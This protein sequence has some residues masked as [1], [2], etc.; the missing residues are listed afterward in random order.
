MFI[1]LYYKSSKQVLHCQVNYINYFY[2]MKVFIYGTIGS[3][4]R[5][6]EIISQIESTKDSA[7]DVYI[8]SPGGSVYE[9]FAIYNALQRHSEKVSTYIDGLAY[10]A[11]SWIS[12][13][14]PAG[15]RFMSRASHF[16]IHQ[17]LNMGGGNKADLEDQ[18]EQL[19]K[20]DEV[21]EFIYSTSSGLSSESI[22]G[23]MESGKPLSYEQALANG[24][25]DGEG[26]DYVQ[27]LA[28]NFNL[29]NNMDLLN[30]FQNFLKGAKGEGSTEEVAE[31]VEAKVAEN[32]EKA[33][34]P[35][36]VLG[37][38]FAKLTDFEEYKANVEPMLTAMFEYIKEQPKEADI[39][40]MVAEKVAEEM[41]GLLSKIKSTATVPTPVEAGY[42]SEQVESFG[43]LTLGDVTS[44]NDF[45][46]K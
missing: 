5:A 13:A 41:K 26:Q 39:N 45:F 10:S 23:L 3:E 32:L 37:K 31:K 42:D 18:I 33:E 20:I 22:R 35:A 46:K 36:E 11:A 6:S 29:N 38:D 7:I 40:K 16:G 2:S 14:A 12:Q 9:G 1:L 27:Q 17:A 24:F 19:A 8:N 43:P 30:D 44:V 15:R 21:Q 25:V 34:T 28:A 4:V